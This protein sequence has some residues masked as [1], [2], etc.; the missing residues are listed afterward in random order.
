MKSVILGTGNLGRRLHQLLVAA[1]QDATL[2][3][4]QAAAGRPSYAEGIVDADLV[5][6][7]IPYFALAEVLPPLAE[8]LLGK[9]VVDCTNP[10][11]EDW[12]PRLLRQ[13]NSAG[14]EVARLLPQSRVVKAFN[15][16]FADV[17]AAERLN[18]SGQKVTAFIAGDDALAKDAVTALAAAAGMAPL[19]AGPLR[20]ARYLEAMAHLNIQIAVGQGGGTNAAFL[21]HQ[22]K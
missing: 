12:S 8:A 22:A 3:A 19:D 10:L 5:I 14:E 18:R 21:Y 2:C 4:R 9:V 7:A 15:T 11:N 20:A 6:L 17:M 16:V 1:G 13:E